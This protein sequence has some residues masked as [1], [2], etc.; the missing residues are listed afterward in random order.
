MS[1]SR[2]MV[3]NFKN[4]QDV[5]NLRV[6]HLE[7]A[8]AGYHHHVELCFF[9]FKYRFRDLPDVMHPAFFGNLGETPKSHGW[10]LVSPLK[11]TFWWHPTIFRHIHPCVVFLLAFFSAAQRC[12]SDTSPMHTVCGFSPH[13][14]SRSQQMLAVDC[15]REHFLKYG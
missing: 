8:M 13:S 7:W 11:S 10:S 4:L 9:F 5:S 12:C 15:H 1:P 6:W 2:P 14:F 3:K